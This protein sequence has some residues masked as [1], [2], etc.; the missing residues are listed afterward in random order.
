MASAANPFSRYY[1]EILRNEG[2]NA[3]LVSDLSGVSSTVLSAYDVVIL[4]EMP[5]TA[6]QVTMFSDWVTAGGNLIAMRP[7][8]KLASLLGLTDAAATLSDAYLLVNTGAAPGAGIVSQTMQFHGT[9]DRYTSPAR[10]PIATL[11]S[12]AEHRDEQ[13][14]RHGP[15]RSGRAAA[16]RRRSPTTWR[17]RSSTRVRAIPRGR[18]RSVT[19]WRRSVLT[20]CSSAAAQADWVDRSKV[21]IPQADEQQRLLANLIQFVNADR[22]PLPHF[23]YLPRGLKAAVVMTGDDH[24]NNGTAGR[25]DI[26]TAN[27]PAGCSVS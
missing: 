7:D 12:D 22:K 10:A 24:G 9:A 6:A 3:F 19:A 5:L 13:P 25:F 1:A 15:Q 26:Y 8:K 16:R 11:Y 14:R 18:A 20:T 4:G 2:L 27:S 17:G 21:A 23:W